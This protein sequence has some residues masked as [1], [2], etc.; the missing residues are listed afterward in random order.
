M[1]VSLGSWPGLLCL[2]AVVLSVASIP[3]LPALTMK[4]TMRKKSKRVP[5][6]QRMKAEKKVREHNRKMRKAGKVGKSGGARGKAKKNAVLGVPNDCPFKEAVLEEVEAARA[7][8]EQERA[9]RRA[10]LKEGVSAQAGARVAKEG[11]L[12]DMLARAKK[13]EE[14]DNGMEVEESTQAPQGRENSAK[15]HYKEFAKV[16]EAADVVLEV[17]DARDPLGT[18]SGEVEKSIRAE[19]KRLVLV[20][21]KA[22]LVPKDNLESWIK[23]LQRE[24]PVVPFKSSTQQQSSR[25]GQLPMTVSKATDAQMQTSK[26]VGVSTVVSLLSNYCRNKDVKTSIRVGVVGF[27]NVGKSSFINSLKRG[28]VCITGNLPG[29]TRQVQEIQLDSKIKLLDSPGMV[30]GKD[31]N[32]D[33]QVSLE[34]HIPNYH[35][36]I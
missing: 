36:L 16:V 7:R 34:I 29:V 19:G 9:A 6:R 10:R 2:L 30:L 15:A 18:R 5:T 25:L 3:S 31:K 28:K 12:D 1:L 20:L 32:N 4:K 17:L 26:A 35:I 33:V 14:E 27:P 11:G 23:H 22:D 24:F 13:G 21:N 8:K